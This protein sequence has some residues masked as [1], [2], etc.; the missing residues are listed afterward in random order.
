M[1]IETEAYNLFEV[2]K[3]QQKHESLN[4]QVKQNKKI[5]NTRSGIWST[6]SEKQSQ[7]TDKGGEKEKKEE[8]YQVISFMII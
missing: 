7:D 1:E 5:S 2:L 8:S 4:T 3:S 6:G